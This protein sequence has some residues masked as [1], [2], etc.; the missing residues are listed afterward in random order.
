MRSPLQHVIE[1]ELDPRPFAGTVRQCSLCRRVQP[2]S[3]FAN[4]ATKPHGHDQECRLCNR[5]RD[6]MPRARVLRLLPPAGGTS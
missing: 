5:E 2:L 6:V 4:D 3:E 1:R